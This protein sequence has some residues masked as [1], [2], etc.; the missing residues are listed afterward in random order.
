MRGKRVEVADNV[1]RLH[2]IRKAA[3]DT[4][5]IRLF[6]SLY[7]RP[8]HHEGRADKEDDAQFHYD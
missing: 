3:T 2:I 1:S 6:S 5:R 4:T 7:Q 8:R